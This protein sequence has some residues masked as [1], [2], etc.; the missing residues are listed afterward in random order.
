MKL[1]RT[2]PSA[3]ALS[4]STRK[5]P[6][7]TEE[8]QMLAA[9]REIKAL[10]KKREAWRDQL[11]KVLAETGPSGL[12]A[13]STSKLTVPREFTLHGSRSTVFKQCL[14]PTVEALHR[15]CR[16][17]RREAPSGKSGGSGGGGARLVEWSRR[18]GR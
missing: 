15:A 16:R 4:A 2:V 12:P 9:A 3:P 5:A 14:D 11:D 13:R 18:E 1:Q 7:T 17:Q 8:Q 10:Q 6:P